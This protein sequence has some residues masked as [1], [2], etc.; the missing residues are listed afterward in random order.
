M[1]RG[2]GSAVPPAA[3]VC[4]SFLLLYVHRVQPSAP[5]IRRFGPSPGW[6]TMA[7]ADFSGSLPHGYPCGSPIRWTEPETSRGKT[8]LLLPDP[9]SEEHTSELQSPC[10]LVCRLLLE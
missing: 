4:G 5:C 3:V 2:F 7:S 6:A 10:N 1:R 9:R 8:C